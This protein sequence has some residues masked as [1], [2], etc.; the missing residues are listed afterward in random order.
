MSETTLQNTCKRGS[1]ARTEDSMGVKGDAHE[2]LVGHE[3]RMA[4][5]KDFPMSASSNV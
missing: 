5:Q 3:P 1:D 4:V 2:D